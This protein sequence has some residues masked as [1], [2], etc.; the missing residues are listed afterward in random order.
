MPYGRILENGGM[1]E[2]MAHLKRAYTFAC[3]NWL[4]W[5]MSNILQMPLT[6]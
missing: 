3:Q 2:A 1:S 5:R 6:T 4:T